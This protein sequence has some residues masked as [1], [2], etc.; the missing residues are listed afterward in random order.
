MSSENDKNALYLV[1]LKAEPDSSS[2]VLSCFLHCVVSTNI[3][4]LTQAEPVNKGNVSCDPSH[5]TSNTG[6]VT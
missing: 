4:E 6:N 2:Y 5:M 3:A 1:I